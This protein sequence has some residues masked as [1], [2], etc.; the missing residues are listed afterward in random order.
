MQRELDRI[1]SHS[2]PDLWPEIERRIDEGPS[3][4]RRPT[5]RVRSRALATVGSL[6]TAAAAMFGLWLAFDLGRGAQPASSG[7]VMTITLRAPEPGDD[8]AVPL[9]SARGSFRG[10]S[11]PLGAAPKYVTWPLPDNF[12]FTLALLGLATPLEPGTPLV[13][14]GD[15]QRVEALIRVDIEQAVEEPLERLDGRWILPREEGSYVLTVVGTWP[16][17]R[18]GFSVG[19]EVSD[20]RPCHEIIPECD[21]SRG[22][23]RVLR[24]GQSSGALTAV[25]GD[26]GAIISFDEALARA[27]EAD[28]HEAEAVRLVLGMADAGSLNWGQGVRPY[29]SVLWEGVCVFSHGPPIRSGDE[30]HPSSV[31]SPRCLSTTWSTVIDARTGEFVVGGP[32]G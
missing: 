20:A 25:N 24:G 5:P 22:S 9:P 26:L 13:I 15:A 6:A 2:S 16:K 28:W 30:S 29:Y 1:R 23:D 19:F 8:E 27:W 3:A 10:T 32:L 12:V 18:M 7:D 31:E 21:L 11:F 14:E 4:S 17:G